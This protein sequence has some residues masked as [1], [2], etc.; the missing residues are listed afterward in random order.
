MIAVEPS[1]EGV[2]LDVANLRRVASM[3]SR[4]KTFLFL[5]SVFA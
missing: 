4:V 5:Q 1:F 3:S 2:V